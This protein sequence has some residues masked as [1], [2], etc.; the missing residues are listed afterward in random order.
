MLQCLVWSVPFSCPLP[1]LIRVENG[2]FTQQNFEWDFRFEK[3]YRD[4]LVQTG[5]TKR[6]SKEDERCR[7]GILESLHKVGVIVRCFHLRPVSKRVSLQR[8]CFSEVFS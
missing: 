3:D 1:F 7:V 6:K 8:L 2:K 5:K 4:H